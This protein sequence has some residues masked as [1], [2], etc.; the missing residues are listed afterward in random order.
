MI[1]RLSWKSFGIGAS[2]VFLFLAFQVKSAQAG[3]CFPTALSGECARWDQ[4]QPVVFHPEGGCLKGEECVQAGGGNGGGSGGC[5][6]FKKAHA[7]EFSNIEGNEMIQRVIDRWMAVPFSKLDI[8]LGSPLDD[9][10]D[11]NFGN[12]ENFW[13]TGSFALTGE[14]S[15]VDV[16]KCYDGGGCFNPVIFDPDGSLIDGILGSCAYTS[17]F[18]IGGSIPL[19]KEDGDLVNTT[20]KSGQLLVSAACLDPA[21]QK[22]GCP[23]CQASLTSDDLEGII[24]HEFGHAL[25][26]DHTLTNKQE[27]L[28]CEKGEAGCTEVDLT[29]LPTMTGLYFD[30]LGRHLVSLHQDDMST[31]ATLYPN[32]V[33]D[34]P[35]NF[36]KKTCTINGFATNSSGLMSGRGLEIVARKVGDPRKIA[37][38]TVAGALTPRTNNDKDPNPND[39]NCANTALN[40]CGQFNIFGLPPGDYTIDVQEIALDTGAPIPFWDEEPFN[41]PFTSTSYFDKLNA[42]NDPPKNTFGNITCT[43]DGFVNVG[44]IFAN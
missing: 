37:V 32:Q 41:P 19:L 40:I 17:V 30:G 42:T 20:L 33:V 26:L 28:E 43:E 12:L 34:S 24:Q 2:I 11:V 3:G 13:S 10:G 23:P 5:N 1:R 4:N 38:A 39:G 21:E 35:N 6:L 16:A 27:Y 9:G 7:V 25:G 8:Q 36:K 44:Q 31:F 29:N 18:G 14:P 22:F 15:K